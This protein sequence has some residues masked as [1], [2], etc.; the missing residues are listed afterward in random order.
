MGSRLL[1]RVMVICLVAVAGAVLMS[2]SGQ[3]VTA[4]AYPHWQRLADP[5]LSPRAHALGVSIGHHV[6]LLGGRSDGALSD[7]A[8]YDLRTGLWHRVVA[9]V[10]FTDRDTA[11]SAGGAVIVR[12]VDPSGGVSWWRYDVRRG[13]WSLMTRLPEGVGVPS[14]FGSEVYAAARG[15]VEV[16]SVQLDRWTA[17]PGDRLHPR[18]RG[19]RVGAGHRGTVVTGYLARHRR[20]VSDRWDGVRWRRLRQG[21]AVPTT[22][23]RS[24]ATRIS[25]G[26]RLVLFRGTQAWIHSP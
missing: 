26:G 19:R 23:R 17:L 15:R 1:S 10:A 4:Q 5:P 7:G 14:A 21:P 8:S 25:V 12:H 18:L 2:G 13:P 9:P 22:P 3:P 6:L 20:P 11:V 24:P 16:Y